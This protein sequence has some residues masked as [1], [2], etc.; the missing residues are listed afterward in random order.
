VAKGAPSSRGKASLMIFA[1]RRSVL[2][3]R[4]RSSRYL[5]LSALGGSIMTISLTVLAVLVGFAAATH[6][7]QISIGQPESHSAEFDF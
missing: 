5:V 1:I 6:A 2:M 4:L 3:K 7:H